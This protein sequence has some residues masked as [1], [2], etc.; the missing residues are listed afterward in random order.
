[1]T[2]T[3]D[4]ALIWNPLSEHAA[5]ARITPRQWI[6]HTAV[7]GPGPTNLHGY[8]EHHTS[9]ESHTW[10]R[11]DRHEQ[12]MDFDRRADANFK[13]NQFW[14]AGASYGAIST[15]TE[16]DGRPVENP[17]NSYQLK[18]LIRFGVWLN[19]T[20]G[21]PPVLPA[22]P[23][24]PG[25]GYHSLFPGVWSNVAGKT[26]PGSTRINQFKTIVLPGIRAALVR[27]TDIHPGRRLVVLS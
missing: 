22:G 15:E 27:P 21:I 6:V 10:L 17:W 25:M 16:D 18:E 7:D 2:I 11:W 26:C 23:F 13:A 12:L 8:F 5:Q 14:I 4:P 19:K 1:M 24:D 20:F 3:R 9:L